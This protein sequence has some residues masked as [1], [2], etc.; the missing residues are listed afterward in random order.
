MKGNNLAAREVVSQ[1]NPA[2]DEHR[3]AHSYWPLLSWNWSSYQLLQYSNDGNIKDL[4]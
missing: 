3:A 4:R 1:K 2:Q